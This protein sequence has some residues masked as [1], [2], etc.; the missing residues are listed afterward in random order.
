MRIASVSCFVV[1]A[2]LSGCFAPPP[3]PASQL[4]CTSTDD[5]PV[6]F[7]CAPALQRCKPADSERQPPGAVDVVVA[8]GPFAPGATIDVGFRSNEPLALPPTVVLLTDPPTAF[9]V[10][11]EDNTF[12]AR[13]TAP[14]G[15]GSVDVVADLIDVAGNTARVA[16]GSVLLDATAPAI[17]TATIVGPSVLGPTALSSTLRVVL[18]ETVT[19]VSAAV[20]AG[21]GDVVVVVDGRT[22]T[23]TITAND[24]TNDAGALPI[25]LTF[26]D[27]AGNVGSTR[28]DGLAFDFD[29]P[30]ASVDAPAAARAGD[31]VTVLFLA[32]EAVQAAE[33]SLVSADGVSVPL[34]TEIV[35]GLRVTVRFAVDELAVDGDVTVSLDRLTDVVGN[36]GSVAPVL[37]V[38]DRTAPSLSGAALVAPARIGANDAFAVTAD[39]SEALAGV[40]L[41]V[42]GVE[43]ENACAVVATD[44]I[45]CGANGAELAS[46][47]IAPVALRLTDVAGNSRLVDAGVITVDVEGPRAVAS[48]IA[49]EPAFAPA[50][51]ADAA[52]PLFSRRD[53]I[54]GE[55]VT[56]VVTILADEDVDADLALTADDGVAVDCE[57]D[58]ARSGECR[59][60]IDDAI[61]AGDHELTLSWTDDLGN[62]RSE[63][64]DVQLRLRTDAPA[65]DIEQ[66][67]LR[68]APWG[69]PGDDSANARLD[70][71]GVGGA[72]DGAVVLVLSEQ[73]ALP[74]A[75]LARA[76]VAVDGSF[77]AFVGGDRGG[78]K[79]IAV[80]TAGVS[81][82]VVDV[83]RVA[84]TATMG[85]KR[86]GSTLENPHTFGLR[87]VMNDHALQQ[88]ES[89]GD[90]R[91]LFASE[92]ASLTSTLAPSWRLTSVPGSGLQGR[93]GSYRIAFDPVQ[94][95]LLALEGGG[96]TFISD[97][98]SWRELPRL[99]SEG[100][101]FPGIAVGVAFSG[102]LGSIVAFDGAF[103]WAF[104]GRSWAQLDVDNQ[105]PGLGAGFAMTQGP[106]G[107]VVVFGGCTGLFC[108][109]QGSVEVGAFVF[110]GFSAVPVAG[111][112][113]RR[114]AFATWDP[115]REVTVV[116]S[117]SNL[118]GTAFTDTWE[119]DDVNAAFVQVNAPGMPTTMSAAGFDPR[120]GDIVAIGT[121]TD[122]RGAGI[123]RYDGSR[124]TLGPPL[125]VPRP[126]FP[127]AAATDQR[128]GSLK[129]ASLVDDDT[130]SLPDFGVF[131]LNDDGFT[132]EFRRRE[133]SVDAI[134]SPSERFETAVALDP[135]TKKPFMVGGRTRNGTGACGTGGSCEDQ[136]RFD[137][138][139]F[140]E[141]TPATKPPARA[142]SAMAFDAFRN[143][144]FLF[145]GAREGDSASLQDTWEYNGTTWVQRC[146]GGTCGAL[147]PVR[148]RHGMAF[149][150]V[151]RTSV[152]FGGEA[153]FFGVPRNDTWK[154][155]GTSWVECRVGNPAC[156]LVVTAAGLPPARADAAMAFDPDHGE[157]VVFGGRDA[158]F[159]RFGDTWTFKNN[160]WTRK[161]TTG[162]APRVEPNLVFHPGLGM[163]LI[164][165][166]L[167]NGVVDPIVWRWDGVT[168]TP[169]ATIDPEFDGDVSNRSATFAA[170][171]GQRT[172]V[173][174]GI[175]AV[176][177]QAWLLDDHR[178]ERPGHVFQARFDVAGAGNAVIDRVDVGYVGGA[179]DGA[180]NGGIDL[181]VW[182][183]DTFVSLSGVADG[184]R[185]AASTGAVS[186]SS[187]NDL[188]F[189]TSDDLARVFS[190]SG[191]VI[192]VA[193]RPRG[194]GGSVVS[195]SIFVTVSYRRELP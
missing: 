58:S 130:G 134:R 39:A 151:S 46:V 55:R 193:A 154:F 74:Q 28:F 17:V 53:P 35:G 117:G 33:A 18:D 168:W 78:V 26:T 68:R 121:N 9:V 161:A 172:V 127:N 1:S 182:R 133:D 148:A 139:A 3:D 6:T 67:V 8:P 140:N 19:A 136:W 112:P 119:F 150:D 111:P 44:S 122:F 42:G 13:L 7:V 40:A 132:I 97:G 167:A 82:A 98:F 110:D 61:T 12:A 65:L 174:S 149:D 23:I 81:S 189:A 166:Q 52:Q 66:V 37:I 51:R 75:L 146:L 56:A 153:S 34:V 162:P 106:A 184:D 50:A 163:L 124:W 147:P 126:F 21:G 195:D 64:L 155:N 102:A 84:W 107:S 171:D 5:C 60:L 43:V 87:P 14:A 188:A 62:Q 164:G 135:A 63:V 179:T 49:R 156:N 54:S 114:S 192:A 101:G 186:W 191:R 183:Q 79:V 71:D 92:G 96:R 30:D 157:V 77:S 145:G 29:A 176:R 25:E 99:D 159:N 16:L 120:S 190:G 118:A 129:F 141:L 104:D 11:S 85:N 57:L 59:R 91:A 93:V 175:S 178:N 116:G 144:V 15:T 27:V 48:V 131:G 83:S 90:G 103:F 180:G 165:G 22:A 125:P 38:V 158:A 137:G 185:G 181:A 115:E 187:D 69:R 76:D 95:A 86:V 194:N 41:F 24:T 152:V 2:A 108:G 128:T 143:R 109:Q 45:V 80:S 170:F 72:T 70:V 105:I 94:G 169:L 31:T 73:G 89:E 4:E 100:D 173:W 177:F 36:V 138:I 88:A 47:G 113:P 10:D 20:A 123:A 142:T 160:T 32:D